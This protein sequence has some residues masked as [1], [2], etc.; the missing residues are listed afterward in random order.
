MVLLVL[1]T[2]LAV[3]PAATGVEPSIPTLVAARDLS[4]GTSLAPGDLRVVD[5]PAPLRP[6]G[7]MDSPDNA[8]GRPLAGAVRA[9]EA[10]TDARLVG[11]RPTAPG[12]A[13]VPVRLADPGIAGLLQAGTKVGVVT[14]GTEHPVPPVA[15]SDHADDLDTA[16]VLTVLPSAEREQDGPLVLLSVP[17]ASATALA[18]ASLGQPVTVTLR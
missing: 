15:N 9:G 17:L 12:T 1:A 8:L 18:S 4:L 16:T 13:T 14:T 10:L 3:H 11:G 6:N 7:A 2:V 5:V